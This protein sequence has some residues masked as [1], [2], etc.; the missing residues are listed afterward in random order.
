MFSLLC[1]NQR[2][3]LTRH[4]QV[5]ASKLSVSTLEHTAHIQKSNRHEHAFGSLKT[6]VWCNNDSLV[7]VA[8]DVLL[9]VWP[10]LH[11]IHERFQCAVLVQTA[12]DEDVC[13][14]QDV[15]HSVVS[16]RRL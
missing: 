15:I 5:H 13:D 6:R 4:G 8:V 7:F 14:H 9:E 12:G 16:K 1:L 10:R 11:A 3:F 2:L